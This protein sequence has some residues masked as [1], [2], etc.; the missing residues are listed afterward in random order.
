MDELAGLV[1]DEAVV[2]ADGV[3]VDS[4]DETEAGGISERGAKISAA[5]VAKMEKIFAGKHYT[6]IKAF[7]LT[8]KK[9]DADKQLRLETPLGNKIVKGYSIKLDEGM[10][11]NE[12]YEAKMIFGKNVLLDAQRTYGA[13]EMPEDVVKAGRPRKSAEEK[14]QAEKDKAQARRILMEALS[15][16]LGF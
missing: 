6:V 1:A 7:D 14:A 13:I 5:R 3:E 10:V 11:P 12:P 8:G 4:E 2:D 15:E 16:E 9:D